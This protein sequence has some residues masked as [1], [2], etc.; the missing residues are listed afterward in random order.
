MVVFCTALMSCDNDI[1][2]LWIT[3]ALAL[4]N[5]RVTCEQRD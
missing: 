1:C 3:F 5:A 2:V 4:Q